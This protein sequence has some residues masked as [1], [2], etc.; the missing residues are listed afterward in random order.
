M[1]YCANDKGGLSRKRVCKKCAKQAVPTLAGTIEAGRCACGKPATTCLGC[2]QSKDKRDVAR[3]VLDAVKKLRGLA[4]SYPG[5]ERADGLNQA[6]D[7][8]EAGGF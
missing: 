5:S 3:L 8:I 4:R 2:A 6:A 1:I 7:V